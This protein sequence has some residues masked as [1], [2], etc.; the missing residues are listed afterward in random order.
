MARVQRL[1]T[2]VSSSFWKLGQAAVFN[3]APLGIVVLALFA[4]LLTLFLIHQL[5]IWISLDPEKAFHAAKQWVEA[6]ATGWNTVAN[7]WNGFVEVLLVAIPGWNAG[8]AYVFQPAVYTALDVFSIAFAGRQYNGILTEDDVP[9]EGFKCPVDGS[10]DKS[11]EWC[12]QVSFYAD[13]LGTASGST[14]DFLSGSQVVL[15]TQTARRLS[16]ATGDPIV[17]P[18]DLSFLMD[19]LQSLL[20]AVIVVVG[21]LSDI[22]FHVAW[23]VLSEVFEVIFNLLI[24]LTKALSSLVM[25]VVRSNLIDVVLK[26]GLNLL[27]VVIMEI[28]IPYYMAMINAFLCL[29]DLFQTAGWMAQ[30]DCSK[31]LS[32]TP[33]PLLFVSMRAI[34]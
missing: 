7:I 5:T 17:G 10:L 32:A 15:S 22:V 18:L 28:M 26:F 34:M 8:I 24:S 20:G 12:G 30:M 2:D 6:Y 3:F 25:M 11:S 16:E 29:I 27:L 1:A 23:T 21:E 14:D 31:C 33:V 19:A 13:Q 9:Y 4:S